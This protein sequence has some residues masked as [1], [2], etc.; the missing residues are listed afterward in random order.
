MAGRD[1]ARAREIGGVKAFLRRGVTNR[2]LNA[3][4][5]WLGDRF[6]CSGFDSE[7]GRG[8]QLCFVRLP[9]Q[10]LVRAAFGGVEP[11][12]WPRA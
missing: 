6:G 1:L 2:P 5:G 9:F 3:G 4:I 11:V 12:V 8:R 10:F 7:A